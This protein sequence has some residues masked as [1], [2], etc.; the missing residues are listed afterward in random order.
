[1]QKIY[2]INDVSDTE[3]HTDSLI[4]K[5]SKMSLEISYSENLNSFTSSFSIV[6]NY[7]D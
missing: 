7:Y 1:M 2:H 4:M 3:H 5:D 6:E